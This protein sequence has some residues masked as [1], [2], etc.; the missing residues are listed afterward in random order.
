MSEIARNLITKKK[1]VTINKK[2]VHDQL[3]WTACYNDMY[4]IHWSKKNRF[5]WYLQKSH[6]KHKNY[7]TTKWSE[8]QSEVKKLAILE[9]KE[10]KEINTHKTQ[11]KDY[12]NSIITVLNLNVN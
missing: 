3:S 12:S 11:I 1:L 10:I 5:E 8:S 4:W 9:K 7:N 2:V 6:K